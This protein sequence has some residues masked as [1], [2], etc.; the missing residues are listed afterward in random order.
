MNATGYESI[1]P[2]F[3]VDTFHVSVKILDLDDIECFKQSLT[4]FSC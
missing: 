3:V 4:L 2:G 1:L